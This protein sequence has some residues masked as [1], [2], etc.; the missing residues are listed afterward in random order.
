VPLPL[1]LSAK[2]A[3]NRLRFW[4]RRPAA[5]FAEVA[6]VGT[7]SGRALSGV[8]H[9]VGEG[10]TD[11]DEAVALLQLF[12]R[13]GEGEV[14]IHLSFQALLH[15]GGAGAAAAVV[16]EAQPGVLGGLEDVLVLGDI[17]GDAALFE[18]Y[19]VCLRHR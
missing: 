2:K 4:P 10:A 8:E 7:L 18:R 12:I 17:Y 11:A 5:L 14:L 16:G 3:S 19:L 15:A 9:D 6:G 1:V 13:D